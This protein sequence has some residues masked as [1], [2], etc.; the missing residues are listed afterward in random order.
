MIVMVHN[1]ASEASDICF[2]SDASEVAKDQ[3]L[4]AAANTGLD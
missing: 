3:V 4:D 1:Q 2:A